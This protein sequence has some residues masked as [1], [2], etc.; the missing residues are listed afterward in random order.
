M[1]EATR[2]WKLMFRNL[3]KSS[4]VPAAE[5]IALQRGSQQHHGTPLWFS[6]DERAIA[7]RP[8]RNIRMHSR[9]QQPDSLS[10]RFLSQ[11][12]RSFIQTNPKPD[13]TPKLHP[14]VLFTGSISKE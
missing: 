3:A 9:S 5:F 14:R 2:V 12:P 10:G 8:P 13:P 7:Q 11:S 4:D 6:D 1:F